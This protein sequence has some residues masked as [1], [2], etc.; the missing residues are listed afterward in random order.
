MIET[1]MTRSSAGRL[2]PEP[3]AQRSLKH[4]HTL[5]IKNA[6]KELLPAPNLSTPH[7]ISNENNEF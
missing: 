4:S 1:N 5:V 3:G 2:E 6:G 7:N